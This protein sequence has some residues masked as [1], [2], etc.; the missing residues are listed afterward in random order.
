MLQ[1]VGLFVTAGVLVGASS[2]VAMAP[3]TA[4]TPSTVAITSPVIG[5]T[6]AGVVDVGV[7]VVP[8]SGPVMQVT[9]QVRDVNGKTVTGTAAVPAGCGAGCDVVVSL[10]AGAPTSDDPAGWDL[11]DGQAQVLAW[12][13]PA[14]PVS[15]AVVLG[16]DRPMI[17]CPSTSVA[18]SIFCGSP[19][20]LGAATVWDISMPIASGGTGSP[21]TSVVFTPAAGG[22]AVPLTESVAGTWSASIDVSGLASAPTGPIGTVVA[23]DARGISAQAVSLEAVVDR[24]LTIT[25]DLSQPVYD[26]QCLRVATK[27]DT[28]TGGLGTTQPSHVTTWIDGAKVNDEDLFIVTPVLNGPDDVNDCAKTTV[29]G[30]YVP[31]PTGDHQVTVTV[32]DNAGNTGSWTGQITILPAMD[33]QIAIDS[34]PDLHKNVP[35]TI[36][37]STSAAANA[38][39]QLNDVILTDNGAHVASATI[40]N[41]GLQ[42]DISTQWWPT[43]YGSHTLTWTVQERHGNDY[44]YTRQVEVLPEATAVLAAPKPTAPGLRQAFTSTVRLAS[45][46]VAAGAT[47]SLQYAAYR[48]TAWTTVATTVTTG[49]GVAAFSVIAHRAGSYRVVTLDHANS[50]WGTTGAALLVKALPV[51]KLTTKVT[52]PGHVA[53]SLATGSTL[54]GTN[55]ILWVN[56]SGRWV[57]LTTGRL[58]SKLTWAKAVSLTH[59]HKWQL[60]VTLATT[61]ISASATSISKTVTP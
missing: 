42:A 47:V 14:A 40:S 56:R 9:A 44:S 36:T 35:V 22:S 7:H 11:N 1:R 33:T 21:V 59:G 43:T 23:T 46:G 20:I 18:G 41:L 4:V 10:N 12:V 34:G 28:A 30:A 2:V 3:A 50:W 52:S 26:G 19:A 13:D 37:S 6:I 39:E 61:T 48:S 15:E 29:G 57:A 25:P 27:Y 31:M 16:N 51:L 58:S 38:D 54:A 49:S 24:V 8:G 45:G 55:V 5:A 53:V 60:R 32:A 17:T